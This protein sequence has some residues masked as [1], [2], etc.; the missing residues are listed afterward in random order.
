MTGWNDPSASLGRPTTD[1]PQ[2]TGDEEGAEAAGDARRWITEAAHL[3]LVVA[4]LGFGDMHLGLDAVVFVALAGALLTA[5]PLLPAGLGFVETGIVGILTVAYGVPAPEA[6]AI[7]FLDRAVTVLSLIAIGFVA[8]TLSGKTGRGLR[9][10][11][12]AVPVARAAVAVPDG[13]EK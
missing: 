11:V 9:R 1:S 4:A 13:R 10:S 12:V 3:A 6:V 7:A 2:R 5:V 8:Y